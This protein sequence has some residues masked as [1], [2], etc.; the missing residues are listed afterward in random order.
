MKGRVVIEIIKNPDRRDIAK[1]QRAQ[2]YGD[3][4]GIIVTRVNS[5]AFRR[6]MEFHKNIAK[7][8]GIAEYVG[9]ML[10]DEYAYIT[11]ATSHV[12]R[13]KEAEELVKRAFPWI[14]GISYFDEDIND[15]WNIVK[16][17]LVAMDYDDNIIP[18][19]KRFSTSKSY[20]NESMN[21]PASL[22]GLASEA[23][24]CKSFDEFEKAFLGQIKHGTYWHWTDDPN[25]T[26]D[27]LKGPRDMS[28]MASGKTIDAGK[29]MI[30]SD[31]DYWS[32]YGTGGKGRKYA[33]L[34]DMS[35]VDSKDYYQVNRG[36]GNEFFVN[37]PSNAVVQK[38]YSRQRAFA[39]DRERRKVLP[40]SSEALEKFYND[41]HGKTIVESI[42]IPLSNEQVK[43]RKKLYF[44]TLERE[45]VNLYDAITMGW[46]DR[47]KELVR[48]GDDLA[49]DLE[50]AVAFRQP[51]IVQLLLDT[52]ADAGWMD[53]H[54]IRVALNSR[55]DDIVR[56][57]IPY[58]KKEDIERLR[59]EYGDREP[60]LNESIDESIF[61]PVPE[62]EAKARKQQYKIMYGTDIIEAVQH[63]DIAYVK[64]CIEQGRNINVKS[65]MG[66]PL[67]LMAVTRGYV[68]MVELLLDNGADP[69]VLTDGKKTPLFE[70]NNVGNDDERKAIARLL[71]DH[72]ADP[73]I[74]I[75]GYTPIQN[76][77]AYGLADVIDILL[78]YGTNY[79]ILSN[80]GNT[81]WDFAVTD[82]NYDIITSLLKHGMNINYQDSQGATALIRSVVNKENRMVDFLLEHGADPNIR[83]NIG[84]TALDMAEEVGNNEAIIM[85]KS[86]GAK[87]GNV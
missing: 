66:R 67:L 28:S 48:P 51:E 29:L 63:N 2:G 47:V 11:D 4:I 58:L 83:T 27:P 13:T 3:E 38:V 15:S 17:E 79:M 53:N 77:L 36:F 21:I 74:D 81:I 70:L 75:T 23:R 8:I 50:T 68:S 14:K 33:A 61:I 35:N 19:S 57:M 87:H 30:T 65:N 80:R 25:F 62:M 37:D 52:G 46:Y 1:I 78:D 44:D 84:F 59:E 41:V 26:I 22:E 31:I 7:K 5:Y 60:G 10:G 6:D 86:H 54:A 45:D 76:A 12:L 69:N 24:K 64:K 16:P 40:Q 32:D 85:L 20:F 56:I 73:N 49:E 18:L 72:G 34:I 39:I 43:K 55:Y 71:L 82:H 42:F 9:V